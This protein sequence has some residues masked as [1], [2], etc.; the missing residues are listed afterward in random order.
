MATLAKSNNA[1]AKKDNQNPVLSFKELIA[2]PEIKNTIM[3]TLGKNRVQTFIGNALVVSQNANLKDCEPNSLFNC[4]LKTATY[5]FPLDSNLSYSY[6]IPYKNKDGEKVAT[7]QMGSKG[8]VDLAYRTN[9]YVRLNVSD[10][11]KGE[12]VGKDIFGEVEIK[13]NPSP[14]RDKLETIGYM[15]AF[16][17]TNGMIKKEYWGIDKFKAHANKYSKAHQNAI[18]TRNT[19]DDQWTNNFDAM[20]RKTLLKQLISKYGPTSFEL[21]DAIKFDQAVIQR[22]DGKEEAIYVDNENDTDVIDT[23]KVYDI[24]TEEPK[25]TVVEDTIVVEPVEEK[26]SEENA[27]TEIQ[28]END[29]DVK[30]IYYGEYLQNKDIYTKEDYPNGDKAYQVHPDG[31]KTIRVRVKK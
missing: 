5:N 14:D 11:K 21:Q 6:I 8:F 4:L 15:A 31:K 13:W 26:K 3:E 19:A 24:N 7:F 29:P 16:Q 22:K 12:V 23:T 2:T 30:I 28:E 25:E 20:C 1:V 10:V 9:K 17:L 27:Q 18:K